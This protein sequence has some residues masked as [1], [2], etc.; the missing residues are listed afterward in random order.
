MDEQLKQEILAIAKKYHL[1]KLVLFGSRARGDHRERS[2]IDLAVYGMPEREQAL[3]LSDM[4]DNIFTLLKL[5]I[6]FMNPKMDPEFLKNIEKDGI[7]LLNNFQRKLENYCNALKRLEE[8]LVEYQAQPITAIRDGAIQRFEF[9]SELSW[10]LM[11]D[12]LQSEG[13]GEFNTP[14]SVL[15]E[16]YAV[17]LIDDNEGWIKLIEDRNLTSHTYDEATSN[18]IFQRITNKYIYLFQQ[19]R[20]TMLK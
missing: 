14:K 16:A 13:F 1:T 8:I 6:V 15:R 20:E 5:D 7:V 3:F 9:T 2:D 4:E 19:L 17:K 12:Y 10:K 18:E 11:K